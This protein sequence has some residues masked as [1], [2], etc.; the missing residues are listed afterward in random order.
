MLKFALLYLLVLA[1][2]LTFNYGAHA[3][4]RMENE[5]QEKEQNS[6][7]PMKPLGLVDGGV[8]HG[9]V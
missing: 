2:I 9:V 8:T 7:K 5:L 4:D 3:E 1:I 6:A